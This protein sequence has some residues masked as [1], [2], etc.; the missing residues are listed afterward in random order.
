MK[1][2][3]NMPLRLFLVIS[4]VIML[5]GIFG[6]LYSNLSFASETLARILWIVVPIVYILFS[7]GVWR[8]IVFAFLL[9]PALLSLHYFFIAEFFTFTLSILF[10]AA[11]IYVV[12]VYLYLVGFGH[13]HIKKLRQ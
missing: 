8:K 11:E 1:L 9:L 2:E 10:T 6:P 4:V 12:I 5:V 13:Y 3:F 7:M